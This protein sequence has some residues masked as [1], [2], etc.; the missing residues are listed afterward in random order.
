MAV[1]LND[2]D[3]AR[4]DVAVNDFVLKRW[5]SAAVRNAQWNGTIR[6]VKYWVY[7]H[8]SSNRICFESIAGGLSERRSLSGNVIYSRT[9]FHQGHYRAPDFLTSRISDHLTCLN[10]F[11]K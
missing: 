5:A 1:E 7:K 10:S 6:L 8:P 11:R 3:K 4:V 9:A 2:D